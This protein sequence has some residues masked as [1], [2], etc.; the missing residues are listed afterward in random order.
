MN[1]ISKDFFSNLDGSIRGL[2]KSRTN[3]DLANSPS[4]SSSEYLANSLDNEKDHFKHLNG[5]IEDEI[6]CEDE[7]ESKNIVIKSFE[8]ERDIYKIGRQTKQT[9]TTKLSKF[10]NDFNEMLYYDKKVS[11]IVDGNSDEEVEDS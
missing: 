9:V 6:N 11:F 1:L 2:V 8:S 4:G 5:I 3:I 10:H 7:K